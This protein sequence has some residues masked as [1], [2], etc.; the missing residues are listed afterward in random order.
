MARARDDEIQGLTH[1]ADI[2]DDIAL[3]EDHQFGVVDEGG[4][5][6]DGQGLAQVLLIEKLGQIDL[7][8]D[9]EGRAP[10][11]WCR[12]R[13]RIGGNLCAAQVT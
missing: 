4:D 9:H 7:F 1:V 10:C 2:G 12:Y 5:F 13:W 11:K 6:F 3:V 8:G